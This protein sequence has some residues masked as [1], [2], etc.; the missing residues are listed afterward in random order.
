MIKVYRMCVFAKNLKF[1]VLACLSFT[2]SSCDDSEAVVG[3]QNASEV[4]ADILDLLEKREGVEPVKVSL[5]EANSGLW[6]LCRAPTA[7]ERKQ[8]MAPKIGRSLVTGSEGEHGGKYLDVSMNELARTG[9]KNG[10][11]YPVGAV[12]IKDKWSLDFPGDQKG[13]ELVKRGVG[14]M[15][16]REKGFDEASGDWEYFYQENGEAVQSGAI[17][18][19]VECHAEAEKTDFVYRNWLKSDQKSENEP[20]RKVLDSYLLSQ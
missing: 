15:I 13:P 4:P 17:V 2:F 18:S 10:G 3:Q 16:K 14:G 9:Q 6:M 8:M 7:E 19:C 12:I 20:W 1:G 5:Q 11:N